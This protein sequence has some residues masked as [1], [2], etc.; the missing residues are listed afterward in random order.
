[1]GK[2]PHVNDQGI[3]SGAAFSLEDVRNR[4]TVRGIRTETV[5][6]LGRKGHKPAIP[7]DG[8]GAGQSGVIAGEDF[9]QRLIHPRGIL[10][11]FA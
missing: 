8:G 3:E 10:P 1:M 5:N 7:Q 9:G 11:H 2:V 4:R 6:G